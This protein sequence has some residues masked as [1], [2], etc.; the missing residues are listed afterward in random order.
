MRV[1][2]KCLFWRAYSAEKVRKKYEESRERIHK[3]SS[4]CINKTHLPQNKRNLHTHTHVVR[5][6]AIERNKRSL[7]A[8]HTCPNVAEMDIKTLKILYL[9]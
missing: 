3:L 6:L 7:P 8:T 5:D 9:N 1:C 2:V 4:E